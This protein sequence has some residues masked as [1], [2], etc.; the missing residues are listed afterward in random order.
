MQVAQDKVHCRV[1]AHEHVLKLCFLASLLIRLCIG[2]W[3]LTGQ[4][5][6][7]QRALSLVLYYKV[8]ST[9]N[10]YDIAYVDICRNLLILEKSIKEQK[11]G[12][13]STQL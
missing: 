4:H 13:L 11:S 6:V 10:I 8:F 12:I 2:D 9:C 3:L 1:L 5:S 7:K